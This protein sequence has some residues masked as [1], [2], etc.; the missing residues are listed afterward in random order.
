MRDRDVCHKIKKSIKIVVG[1][2][3]EEEC[4][5]LQWDL[6]WAKIS[7]FWAIF[8]ALDENFG[9]VYIMASVTFLF[10]A[11]RASLM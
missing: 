10:C 6:I 11:K 7:L 2:G 9:E 1:P 3:G 4:W 8:L 5:T